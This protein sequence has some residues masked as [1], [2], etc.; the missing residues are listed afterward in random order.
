VSALQWLFPGFLFGAA[1]VALPI[2]LHLIRRRPKR[3]VAFPSLRFLAATQPRNESSQRLRRW[4]VLLMRCAA[5]ALIAAAFARPFFN[6]F[7]AGDRQAVAIVVDN[8]FSV[9]AAG[10][11]PAL[12]Q[13]ARQ[14]L[15]DLGPADKVGVLVMSPRPTWIVPLATGSAP[16]LQA[17]E[18]LAPGWEP[19]R[20]EPALRLAGDAL[21]AAAADQR[22]ILYLGDHQ[23]VSWAGCDFGKKLP[24]GVHA[25]FP[26]VPEPLARQAAI[27]PPTVTRTA[28]GLHAVV[29][30]QNF[31]A[32]QSRTLRVYRDG[33]VVPARE[34]AV[35]LLDRESATISL[36]WA[37]QD[38]A[39]T[40]YFRFALDPDDLAADDQTFAVWRATGEN[41]VLLDAAPREGGADYVGTA[42]GASAAM[43]PTFQVLPLP[44]AN[45]PAQAVAVLRNDASFAGEAG[46][47]LELF[48]RAGGRALI[49]M[50]G[51]GA[52]AKWLASHASLDA[53]PLKA[54]GDELVVRDWAMDH[55]LVA[56]LSTHS[57]RPLIDW[58]FRRGWALPTDAVEPLALWPDGSAAIGE[59]SGAAGRMLICGFA[60]DRRDSEWPAREM[61][62]PFVHRAVAY[63]VGSGQAVEKPAR[64]GAALTLPAESGN[65]RALAGPAA[66]N[67]ASVAGGVV[68]PAAP[69][70]YEF[71]FGTGKK[72]FAVNLAPE[73]SDPAAWTDG[74]PW[75]KLESEA[76]PPAAT[77]SRVPVESAEAEARAPLWWWLAVVIG[78]LL[79]AELALANRTAR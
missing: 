73:E 18:H 2:L 74:T 55:A 15:A 42:L 61:F 31:T 38:S 78:V 1:A 29:P 76:P 59:T 63:L 17:L 8:S 16:A 44:A 65:W 79:A 75:L 53:K 23:R 45:W 56:G 64:V 43:P 5:L 46:A 69:G 60:A 40:A 6:R 21:A 49:F 68:S 26:S 67:S 19:G 9:Q 32:A 30:I 72:L 77:R 48:L 10:R 57:V 54:D 13:W 27:R 36:D 4:L 51:G 3:T 58:R 12:Q 41:L 25:A 37:A 20:A 35:A 22:R 34:Q 62:V 71:D 28:T 50:D 11:W 66:G 47:R 7:A 70:V 33:A 24:P 14:Q 52:Q 39:D